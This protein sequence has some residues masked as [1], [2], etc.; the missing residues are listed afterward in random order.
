MKLSRISLC[1]LAW[2]G[3]ATAPAFAALGGSP[4]TVQADQARMKG[5]VRVS[6]SGA[7]AVH[8]IS[9]DYGESV[10]EYAG[11]DGRVFAVA[12][13]GPV[14]P[15]LKQLLGTYYGQYQ[16]AG[17]RAHGNHRHLA[18]RQ[19]DLVFENSGR[20]RAFAGRAW[21]PSLLPANFST[22]DIR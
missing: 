20:M 10:R 7:I 8:E 13:N 4:Q 15:D 2:L 16:R 1:V 6:T 14:N 19:P 18:I 21:V 12:W 5:A 9:T 11:S 3:A 22:A 17:A